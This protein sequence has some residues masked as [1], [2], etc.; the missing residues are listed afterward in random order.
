M[1]SPDAR[2]VYFKWPWGQSDPEKG[3][4]SRTAYPLFPQLCHRP[5]TQTLALMEVPVTPT[6]T[7]TRASVLVDSTEGTARKVTRE[8]M[9]MGRG[10]GQGRS[11]ALLGAG[12]GRGVPLPSLPSAPRRAPSLQLFVR[13][14]SFIR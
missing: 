8:G 10:M 5:A 6:R 14:R 11:E 12:R 13:L 9:E 7:P 1:N 3:L 4:W 2:R